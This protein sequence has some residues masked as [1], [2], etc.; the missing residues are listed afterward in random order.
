MFSFSLQPYQYRKACRGIISWIFLIFT[1]LNAMEINDL[2]F[3]ED[4][5][6]HAQTDQS[7]MPFL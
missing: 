3:I 7:N 4:T 2:S 5:L 6:E 1:I